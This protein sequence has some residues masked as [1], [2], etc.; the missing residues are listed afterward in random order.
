MKFERKSRKLI[1]FRLDAK[2][3]AVTDPVEQ[4]E[5]SEAIER[6]EPFGLIAVQRLM[7]SSNPRVGEMKLEEMV[8][9][10]IMRKLDDSGFIIG[11]I[12][13]I[14]LGDRGAELEG[15]RSQNKILKVPQVGPPDE[16]IADIDMPDGNLASLEP[17]AY[18]DGR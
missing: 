15:R 8:D 12:L 4:L 18:T 5:R 3:R 7:L 1:A 2:S 16:Q 13:L 10:S 14:P 11:C 6:L 17:I 9:R